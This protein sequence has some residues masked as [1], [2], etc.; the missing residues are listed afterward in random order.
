MLCG[1]YAK[2]WVWRKR[3]Q[4]NLLYGNTSTLRIHHPPCPHPAS[5]QHNTLKRALLCMCVCFKLSSISWTTILSTLTICAPIGNVN[6]GREFTSHT[7]TYIQTAGSV[8]TVRW[9][10]TAC[11]SH[12]GPT[13]EKVMP[14]FIIFFV[15]L[16]F[17][18][19]LKVNTILHCQAEGQ[20]KHIYILHSFNIFNQQV[21]KIHID[22]L[23]F[24]IYIQKTL[25]NIYCFFIV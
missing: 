1:A 8:F 22:F 24:N 5:T 20:Y 14:K 13:S 17:W 4:A 18:M 7:H 6:I 16:R 3:E 12:N 10:C 11:L 2:W 9:F 21:V 15:L 25:V 23:N 19:E